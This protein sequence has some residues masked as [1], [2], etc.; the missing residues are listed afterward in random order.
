[1]ADSLR[2]EIRRHAIGEGCEFP[3]CSCGCR[4][5]RTHAWLVHP[6]PSQPQV[7]LHALPA[8]APACRICSH[9]LPA[10]L[11][12]LM[13]I[14]S[15]NASM[16]EDACIVGTHPEALYEGHAS[17]IVVAIL[18]TPTSPRHHLRA[19]TCSYTTQDVL[20]SC[21]SSVLET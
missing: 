13:H 11:C 6:N 18:H 4:G 1:M 2:Y 14:S 17:R 8:S 12:I 10:L 20:T 3:S 5:R 7:E 19:A 21:E 16:C 15:A 9:L